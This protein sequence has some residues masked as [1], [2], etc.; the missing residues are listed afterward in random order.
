MQQT[1]FD[2]ATLIDKYG[3][4]TNQWTWLYEA[5]LKVSMTKIALWIRDC[6]DDRAA[7]SAIKAGNGLVMTGLARYWWI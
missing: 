1:Y 3:V 4:L 2:I 5:L 7:K 6:A